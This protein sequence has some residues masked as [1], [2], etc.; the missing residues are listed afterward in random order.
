VYWMIGIG[1]AYRIYAE[2]STSVVTRAK[3]KSLHVHG[4]R[5]TL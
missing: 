1:S 4:E 2:G 3:V 5:K